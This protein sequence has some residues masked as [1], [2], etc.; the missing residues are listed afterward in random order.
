[1]WIIFTASEM[2]QDTSVANAAGKLENDGMKLQKEGTYNTCNVHKETA[3][4]YY[5]CVMVYVYAC[6]RLKLDL[7]SD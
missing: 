4:L 7:R 1:L 2:Q 3:S 6:V 5:G